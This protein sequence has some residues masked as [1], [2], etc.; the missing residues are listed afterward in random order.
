MPACSPTTRTTRTRCTSRPRFD[1]T[2]TRLAEQLV[3]RHELAG[4]HVA[5]IGSGKGEFLALLCERGS[6]S[7]TGFD[8]SYDGES[9]GRAGGRLTFVPEL[10]G[11]RSDLGDAALVLLRHVVEHLEDPVGVLALVRE[12]LGERPATVYVEIPAAEYLIDEQAIW[13]VIY[14][15]VTCLSAGALAGVLERAG[16]HPGAYGYTFGGQYLWMEAGTTPAPELRS[17]GKRPGQGRAA[18]GGAGD[19]P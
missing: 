6:C 10:Y 12:A 19:E 4:K 7:G 15:H 8:P 17:N 1:A 2:P 16:F 11:A 9:D 18:G 3:E 14:P 13:D 5:E